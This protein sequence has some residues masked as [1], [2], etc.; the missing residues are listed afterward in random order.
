VR[1]AQ[2]PGE[3]VVDVDGVVAVAHGQVAVANSV[4][5]VEE[6]VHRVDA[7]LAGLGAGADNCP[8]EA[9]VPSTTSPAETTAVTCSPSCTPPTTS[10]GR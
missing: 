4:V 9:F 3:D 7:S 1:P 8:L 6:C 2:R 10:C 5:A